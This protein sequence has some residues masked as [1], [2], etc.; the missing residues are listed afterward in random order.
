MRFELDPRQHVSPGCAAL[1]PVAAFVTAFLIAGLVIWL[2]GRS[3][4]AAFEV[5]VSQPLSDPWAL[6]ELVVKATPLALIAIGLSYCFR[7][8]LWNIGAEGQYI[9]R[10]HL[11]RLARAEDPRH[12]CGV[13][14][15]AR[16][17]AARHHRRHALRR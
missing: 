12:G 2:L 14:G 10:R 6:Q 5:Y 16:D 1:A 13:L 8:N 4:V 3:P 11:R 17:A 9:D 7:A 15:A